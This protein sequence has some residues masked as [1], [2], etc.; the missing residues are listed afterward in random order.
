[1]GTS[2]TEQVGYG[3]ALLGLGVLGFLPQFGGPGYEAALG[4]ALILPALNAVVTA[5]GALAEGSPRAAFE[6][7]LLRG[8][9]LSAGGLAV[10]L[11][12]GA[13]V[14]M[15]DTAEGVLLFLLSA[16][17]GALLGGAWGAIAGTA[18]RSWMQGRVARVV[19][20]VLLALL[21]P[22]GGIVLS[23]LRFYTSPM[24]FAYDP[25]FGY[26]SGPLYDT[27]I[28][29]L[30]T[31]TT[32]RVGT[33]FTLCAAAAFFLLLER[34]QH[35]R[36]RLRWRERPNAVWACLVLLSASVAL[37]AFGADL[38]HYSTTKSIEQALGRRL[39]S[40]RC[41]IIYSSSIPRRD[42]ER[43]GTECNAHLTQLER[44][45][46]VNGP[47]EVRVFLFGSDVEKGRLMGAART[48]I[49]KPWRNEVYLQPAGYPH[50]VLGHE[51]AHVVAGSFG[52]GPFRVAGPLAGWVPD[53]GRI[54]GIAMAAAPDE[55]DALTL[56]E[57]AAAMRRAKL[58]PALPSLFRLSFLGHNAAQAYT[59]AGAFLRFL[60]AEQGAEVIRR[61]YAG[62]TLESIVHQPLSTIEARWHR[63]LDAV[64]LS[65]AALTTARARF[66]RPA[67][68]ARRCPRVIDRSA[69]LAQ[70]RLAGGDVQG[71]REAFTSVLRLDP[72]DSGAR[73]GLA[74]CKAR[75]GQISQASEAYGVLSEANDAAPWARS[76]AQ[77]AMADLALRQ[78]QVELAR[79]GYQ[80]L[81]TTTAD[82]DRLRTLDVKQLAD[83]GIAREAIV[84]LLIGDEL[85]PSWDVAAA[86]L[87]EWAARDPE[88][89]VADYLLGR[90]LM[91]RARYREAAFYFD[92]AL[93][94]RLL[95]PRI[96]EEALRLRLIVGC[97]SADSYTASWALGRLLERRL[98]SSRLQGIQRFAE[99]CAL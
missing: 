17:F 61:W 58:L 88:L 67:F 11:L 66:D 95:E 4:A 2:R 32:Y 16:G 86:K 50:P 81:A 44:F 35:G 57:W 15:C 23:F 99:R 76:A 56:E 75:E 29:S 92:R 27:V 38:G 49:A 93:S 51:L 60:H 7:G 14:G 26:F 89:G 25:F 22:L 94:R 83:A 85:G 20:A 52:S 37:T 39:S 63:S 65:T 21:G 47:D 42:A 53:P 28:G 41:D 18:A 78:G 90:N 43:L 84:L 48:Y 6:R 19:V 54:E 79:K 68:F 12:H 46:A 3:L 80:Q 1:M 45:F 97:A 64:T 5:L 98:S 59:A 10:T 74:A 9:I 91:S 69:A 24:V 72:H 70:A 87:G 77:E 62:E 55:N 73:L 96:L 13:R 71:A 82:E 8:F 31:L 34:D 33:L 40:G 30:G 36:L